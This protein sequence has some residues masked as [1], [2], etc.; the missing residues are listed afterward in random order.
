[1]AKKTNESKE[2]KQALKQKNSEYLWSMSLAPKIGESTPWIQMLVISFFTAI[3]ILITRLHSYKRDLSDF[4]WNG[5]HDDFSDFFSYFKM[6]AICICAGLVIIFLLYR[7]FSQSLYVKKSFAYIPMLIYSIFVLLSYLFSDYKE[8]A[9]LGWND[10]F[11]GTIVL[12]S[13][14]IMLFFIVNSVN[15]EKNVKWIIYPLAGSS[16]LLSLLGL[17]Q[18]LNKDFFRTVIGQKLL[19]PNEL[20]KEGYVW[21]LID[22]AKENGKQY[23]S[24]TFQHKE[25]YQTVYNTNYVSFYLTLLIPLFGMLFIRSISKGKEAPLWTKICW[26][27][28][29]ALTIF[30][31]IGSASSG[32]LLGL[33]VLVIVGIIVLNKRILTWWKPVIML[34]IITIIISGITYQRWSTELLSAVDG[35]IGKN[36]QTNEAVN[37]DKSDSETVK[38]HIDYMETTGSALALSIE[39]NELTVNTYIDDPLSVKILDSD[40]KNLSLAETDVSPVYKIDD[41]RFNMIT[42]R[43]AQD[44]DGNNYIIVGTDEYE[45]PFRLTKGGIKYR[46]GMA[47]YTDLY[48]IHSIGFE[49]NQGFGSGRGYI[50]SRSLPLIK[51]TLFI[52]HGADT[53][54]AYFPHN[55]YVGKYNTRLF[56]SNINIIVDKPHNMYIGMAI[57][58]GCISVLA[59]L[60]LWAM[61]IIQSIKIYWKENYTTYNSYVGIGIFLGIC[62]FLIS[63]I[64]NDSSVSVMPL[65][66]GLLGTGMA[67]NIMLKQA[68]E[69]LS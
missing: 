28:L 21:D 56:S 49:N 39:G 64:V 41:K 23:L 15:T 3:I 37:N 10:R 61:Y 31:L 65:F 57:G 67:I 48:R 22:K 11:E 26:G 47:T 54:C 2:K 9:W 45:W 32:G 42:I 29:F 68:K 16:V 18:A 12:L 1:M 40:G 17:S 66:Y 43:P 52:G 25:I 35:V 38:H 24:F 62:G 4:Y 44:K 46:T 20:T 7:I 27:V 8:F 58:T 13:Y 36:V 51:D 30:N 63:A 50:W 53:Y 6:T 60:A 34:I 5:P 33:A 14:M 55:D 19:V 59:L 69:S